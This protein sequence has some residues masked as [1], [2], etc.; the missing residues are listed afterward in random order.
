MTGLIKGLI[1]FA[2]FAIVSAAIIFAVVLAVA[3]I[4]NILESIP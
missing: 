4:I 3:G 2:S 1:A